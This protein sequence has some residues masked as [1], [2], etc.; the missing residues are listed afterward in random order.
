MYTYMHVAS[1][2][3]HASISNHKHPLGSSCL[4]SEGPAQKFKI[5][6]KAVEVGEEEE[7]RDNGRVSHWFLPLSHIKSTSIIIYFPAFTNQVL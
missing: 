4:Y 6:R 2:T 7:E 5:R 1:N 3:I